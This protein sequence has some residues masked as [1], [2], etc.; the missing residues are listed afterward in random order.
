M[1]VGL[2]QLVMYKMSR[3]VIVLK[4]NMSDDYLNV[5]KL[6]SLSNIKCLAVLFHKV[7]YV[8]GKYHNE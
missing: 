3:R 2:N 1:I 6:K 7:L 8:L 4:Y 5:C